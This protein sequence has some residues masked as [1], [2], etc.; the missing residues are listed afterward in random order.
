MNVSLGRVLNLLNSGLSIIPIGDKKVPWIRWKQYQTSQIKKEELE[1][2]ANDSRTKGFGIVTGF[3]NLECIDVDLKVFPNLQDQKS[4]WDSFIGMLKDHIDDFDK[5]F[6]IYKTINSGYHLI[7]KC[8]QIEGNKK[9]ATLKGHDSAIIETRG[10]GGYIFVYENQISKDLSYEDIKE[11][12]IDDRTILF[13][14]CKYFDYQESIDIDLPKSENEGLTPWDD[15]NNRNKAIDIVTDEFEIVRSLSDRYALRKKGSKDPLHG[16]IY[17][18]TGLAYLF[19]TATIYPHEKAL[20]AFSLYSYKFHNGNFSNAASELYKKGFGE[21]KKKEAVFNTE[22]NQIKNLEFPIDV[23]PKNIQAYMIESNK[24]LNLVI[25]Y[26]ACTLLYSVSLIIGN[27]IKIEVKP[28]WREACNIWIGL[29]GNPGIGKTPSINAILFPLLRKNAFEIKQYQAEYKKWKEY[30]KLSKEEKKNHEEITEPNKK[31]FIVAD[32]TIEA[33][34]ELH[35]QNPNSIGVHKDELNGWIKDMNKYKQGSDQEFW[36][37]SWSNSQAI[38]TR[39]TS[40]SSFIDSP[41]IQVIGGIQPGIFGQIAT[42]ENKSNGFSDR[43]LV[44]Y[45][46]LTVPKYNPNSMNQEMIDWYEGYMT[47]FY[48]SIMNHVLEFDEFGE[49]RPYI[50]RWDNESEKEWIRIF[51]DISEL[52]NSDDENEFVKSMLS[53]QKSYIPR[54]AL[55]LNSLYSYDE[56]ENK[57]PINWIKKDAILGAEK[58]SKYFIEMAKKIKFDSIESISLRSLIKSIN[59][60]PLEE[61]IKQIFETL[62]DANKTEVAEILNC[63]RKTI[64][65]HLKK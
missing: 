28:G 43:L 27:A 9:I 8:E 10:I 44:S 15:F 49:I 38:L 26:M 55:F 63:S 5:K 2:V 36:L 54:F 18:D 41:C 51:N 58:L 30:E 34:V 22:K 56:S 45:P 21:R 60:L 13:G 12:S 19:T 48:N 33:L 25:D 7:Y 62:P 16:Y 14:I 46:N 53:K 64:Y 65:K 23:F 11:I 61:K 29:I 52:Q 20:S 57:R 24:T 4:F 39:K 59:E 6:V 32:V 40:S 31:Q 35:E 50:A 47:G 42:E 3:N 37:S 17:K 1:R